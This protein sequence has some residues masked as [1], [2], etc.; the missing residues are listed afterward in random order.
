MDTKKLA[1]S[2]LECVEVKID[3]NKLAAVLIDEVLEP[4]LDK[5][6]KDSANPVDDAVKAMIYPVLEKEI[7]ELIAKKVVVLEEEIKKKL[8]ELKA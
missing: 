7:K 6:V 4:A 3:L 1:K 5:V 2:A 8:D